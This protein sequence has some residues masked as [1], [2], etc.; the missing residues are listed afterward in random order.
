MEDLFG[1]FTIVVLL[2]PRST[3]KKMAIKLDQLRWWRF[4]V[5]WVLAT[6]SSIPP[7]RYQRFVVPIPAQRHANQRRLDG[8]NK[9][10]VI[11]HFVHKIFAHKSAFSW[12]YIVN[13]IVKTFFYPMNSYC[14]PL[15]VS[16]GGG[17][18]R[19]FNNAERRRRVLAFLW[20]RC[21]SVDCGCC[22]Q[23]GTMQKPTFYI[24]LVYA[25]METW[26]FMFF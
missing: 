7:E 2:S 4:P 13:V 25:G 16:S 21:G 6:A 15:R 24:G 12:I 8:L 19:L 1:C 5:R 18:Y 22:W 26:N 17:L 10:A 3:A 14:A 11:T 20:L 9:H 23:R